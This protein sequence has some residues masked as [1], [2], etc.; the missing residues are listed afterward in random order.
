MEVLGN[1]A[2][3]V[4]NVGLGA[5]EPLAE[6]IVFLAEPVELSVTALDCSPERLGDLVGSRRH[7]HRPSAAI[8]MR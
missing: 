7:A 6:P 3:E 8:S 5:L 2:A 4:E 1:V